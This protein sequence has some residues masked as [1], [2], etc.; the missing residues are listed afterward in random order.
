MVDDPRS[1]VRSS[2]ERSSILR[3]CRPLLFSSRLLRLVSAFFVV[4]LTSCFLPLLTEPSSLSASRSTIKTDN[5]LLSVKDLR[6][7][8]TSITQFRP[9]LQTILLFWLGLVVSI[10]IVRLVN[11][12]FR[13]AYYSVIWNRTAS[14]SHSKKDRIQTGRSRK[15]SGTGLANKMTTIAIDGLNYA[16][17]AK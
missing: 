9:S 15:A 1:A 16:N 10:F 17:E 3:F 14:Q 7:G 11:S 6:L 8:P 13:V 12:A 5:L 2:K 4:S